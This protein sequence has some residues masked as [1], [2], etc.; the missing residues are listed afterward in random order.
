MTPSSLTL[1]QAMKL[2][3]EAFLPCGCVTSANAASRAPGCARRWRSQTQASGPIASTTPSSAMR[4]SGDRSTRATESMNPQ[5][6][7]GRP[8]SSH[9]AD[10]R[11][12][13]CRSR[14]TLEASGR[15]GSRIIQLPMGSTM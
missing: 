5:R 10:A 1:D 15:A 3:T 12:R 8:G 4:A 6:V 13:R 14:F 7:A 2:T 11:S 9:D